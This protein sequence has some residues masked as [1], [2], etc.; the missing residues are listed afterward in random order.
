MPDLAGP[1]YDEAYLD[2]GVPRPHYAAVLEALGEPG[3]MA[4]RVKERLRARGVA[5]GGAADGIFA[6]DPVPRILTAAEWSELELGVAQRVRALDAFV[7]DVYGE[8]R[9]VAEGVVPRETVEGS[10]HYEPTMRGAPVSRWVQV[11]N[12]GR[13]AS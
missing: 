5:F 1:A 12:S 13:C 9:A 2:G 10:D 8:G 6:L 3:E 4:A 7:A 11:P